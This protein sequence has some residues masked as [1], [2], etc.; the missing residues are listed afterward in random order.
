MDRY[1]RSEGGEFTVMA[2]VDENERLLLGWSRANHEFDIH[3]KGVIFILTKLLKNVI[4][5]V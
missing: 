3:R 2:V 4:F 1:S 5:L